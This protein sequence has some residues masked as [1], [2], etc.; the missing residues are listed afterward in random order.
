MTAGY[1]GTPLAAKLGIKP[2]STVLVVNAP[3]DF[4]ALLDPMPEGVRLG[5]RYRS[6]DVCVVFAMTVKEMSSGIARASKAIPQDGAIW[7]CW[8]KRASG[9]AS[10]L[11]TRE[12]VMEHMLP[13]G[14][15]DVKVAAVSEVW[16][17]LKFVIRKELRT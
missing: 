10:P 6:A 7:L 8:P 3:A 17:G 14:L 12:V 4:A 15:V 16:S 13:L 5:N 11:Q 9:I 1:S 2:G